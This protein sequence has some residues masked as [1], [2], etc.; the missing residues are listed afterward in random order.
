MAKKFNEKEAEQYLTANGWEKNR[1]G[2]YIANVV[3][4]ENDIIKYQIKIESRSFRVE[5]KS[6]SGT[7]ISLGGGK[8]IYKSNY[9]QIQELLKEY[10][11]FDIKHQ[12]DLPIT[13]KK[14]DKA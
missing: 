4:G 9:T 14:A 1:F 11:L 6:T 8:T 3:R 13:L 2:N 7:W 5:K 12:K 10:N